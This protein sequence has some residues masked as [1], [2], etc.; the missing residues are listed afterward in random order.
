MRKGFIN[1]LRRAAKPV[2]A[3][4]AGS[5]QCRIAV[6]GLR[7]SGKTV[8][9]TSLINHLK[10]HDPDL[11]CIG[12]AR[13]KIG[14]LGDVSSKNGND[15]PYDGYR[16]RMGKDGCWPEKSVVDAQFKCRIR[17]SHLISKEVLLDLRDF[18]GERF[19]DA[20][21]YEKDFSEWSRLLLAWCENDP[22]YSEEVRPYLDLLGQNGVGE[23][24]VLREYRRLLAKLAR[25]YKPLI[26][27]STFLLDREGKQAACRPRDDDYA[28]RYLGVDADRQF[29]P[30]SDRFMRNHGEIAARFTENFKQYQK[31]CVT[32]MIKSLRGCDRLLFLVDVPAILSSGPGMLHDCLDI[33]K[34]LL[35]AATPGTRNWYADLARDAASYLMPAKWQPGGIRKICFVASKAD[36]MSEHDQGCLISL[37]Q[38][39]TKGI[40]GRLEGVDVRFFVC[41]AVVSAAPHQGQSGAWLKGKVMAASDGTRLSPDEDVVAFSLGKPAPKTWPHSWDAREYRFPY[42]YPQFPPLDFHPPQQRGLDTILDFL[43]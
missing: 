32:P 24:E 40:V 7:N 26:S 29:A 27:P 35:E 42:V 2:L 3:P 11:F 30:L 13:S 1:R 34:Y 38:E 10:H 43:L 33:I 22:D 4:L 21:M 25:L 18:P 5:Y 36:Q 20:L 41:S 14:Y 8:L 19:A 39:M 12:P 23:E 31:Q 17:P 6:S 28:D 16:R 37:L 15:F 9:L